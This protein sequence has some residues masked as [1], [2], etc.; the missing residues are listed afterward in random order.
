MVIRGLTP[1]LARALELDVR[2][3]VYNTETIDELGALNPPAPEKGGRAGTPA[4]VHIKIETGTHRQGVLVSDLP[5]FAER[6]KKYDSVAVEGVTTHFANIEDTTN[7][8]YYREQLGEFQKGIDTLQEHG[9]T[10]EIR[11]CSAAGAGLL[12]PESH[13]EMVRVGVSL[14]GLWPSEKV[15]NAYKKMG[16]AEDLRPAL[17]WKARIAQVK[18]LPEGKYIG[19]G[20]AHQTTRTTT[21]ALIPI[22]YSDGFV[23]SMAG[24][25]SVLVRGKR[26]PLLG[27]VSMNNIVVDVTDIP[28]V[29]LEDEVVLI[30]RQGGDEISMEEF[31]SWAD[32]IN[33]EIPTRISAC[34]YGSVPRI[35]V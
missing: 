35:F 28:G 10:P 9:I 32:T 25:A 19:Y 4:R 24:R 12:F 7:D 27:R 16:G 30:G 33:Y 31:A 26:A 22:G 5:A 34:V 8:A 14:Y 23:R 1:D 13:F 2:L 17:S 20:C 21:M 6:I 11:H 29:A 18:T 3:V 15:H